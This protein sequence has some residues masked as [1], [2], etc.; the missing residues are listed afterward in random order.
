MNAAFEFTQCGPLID[1]GVAGKC[2]ALIGL[3]AGGAALGLEG[4]R[5]LF[6]QVTGARRLADGSLELRSARDGS[7][8]AAPASVQVVE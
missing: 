1:P 2:P 5:A 7:W 8:K 6:A 3:A 4:P